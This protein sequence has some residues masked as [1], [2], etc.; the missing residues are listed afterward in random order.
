MAIRLT[1]REMDIMAILWARGPATVA[2]V[3]EDLEADL[4]YTTV[5]TILRGLEAKRYV[6]HAKEGK[7]HRYSATV[8]AADAGERPLMRVLDKVYQG[9]RELMIA[10]LVADDDVTAAEL[11]RIRRLLAER[12]KE[13][14]E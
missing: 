5:L 9:S 2:E 8:E 13:V 3:L 7:A 14:D 6:R 4:A 10:R 12:L 11:K 1:N